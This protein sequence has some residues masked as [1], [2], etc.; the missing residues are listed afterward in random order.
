MGGCILTSKL[1]SLARDWRLPECLFIN[2]NRCLK[3]T[4]QFVLGAALSIFPYGNRCYYESYLR[5][6]GEKCKGYSAKLM[7]YDSHVYLPQK[8]MFLISKEQIY[9]INIICI[10]FCMLCVTC[11]YI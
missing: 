11:N 10:A 3:V 9:I 1:R 4:E 8:P 5:V 2:E 6:Q 7:R